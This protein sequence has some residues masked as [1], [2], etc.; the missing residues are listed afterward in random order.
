M[1]GITILGFV[2]ILCVV[3]ANNAGSGFLN[4]ITN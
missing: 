2:I 1:V 3:A 4:E